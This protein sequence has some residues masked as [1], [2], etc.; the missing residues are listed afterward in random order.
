MVYVGPFDW[1]VTVELPPPAADAVLGP[2]AP[3]GFGELAQAPTTKE[4]TADATTNLARVRFG[5]NID[6]EYTE[7]QNRMFG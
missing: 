7:S 4:I 6:R 1:V 5:L 2:G 3:A